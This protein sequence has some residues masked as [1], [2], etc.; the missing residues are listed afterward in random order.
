MDIKIL[1]KEE[2]LRYY[3]N[4][5]YKEEINSKNQKISLD[6]SGCKNITDVDNLG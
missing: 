4:E 6:L 1:N 3:E 2:S 5:K